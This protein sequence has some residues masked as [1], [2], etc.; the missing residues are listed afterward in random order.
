V[1]CK[2]EKKKDRGDLAILLRL[3]LIPMAIR[4]LQCVKEKKI[5][6]GLPCLWK[7][8]KLKFVFNRTT[9]IVIRLK[10]WIQ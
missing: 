9:T 4:C 7:N 10:T 8:I 3:G 6:N 5:E 1:S 2:G